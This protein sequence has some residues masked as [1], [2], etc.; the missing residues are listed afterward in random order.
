MMLDIMLG[1]PICFIRFWYDNLTQQTGSTELPQRKICGSL[2]VL[3][4]N[5]GDIGIYDGN[6]V[7]FPSEKI[8]SR[9]F[10][11]AEGQVISKL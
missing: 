4:G 8:A 6:T 3:I 9:C 2:T 5:A 10:P 11:S 1:L 7:V